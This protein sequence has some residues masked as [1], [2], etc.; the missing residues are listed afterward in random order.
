MA[1]KPLRRRQAGDFQDQLAAHGAGE[2]LEGLGDDGKGAGAADHAM[3]VKKVQ[4]GDAVIAAQAAALVQDRQAV[5]GHAGGNGAVAGRHH[6]AARVVGAVAGNIDDPARAGEGVGLDEGHGKIDGAADRGAARAGQR[7]YG[8][9]FGKGMGAVGAVDHPPIG[10]HHGEA[11][12]GP[13]EISHR[14]APQ[15]AALDGLNDARVAEGVDIALALQLGLG[16]IDAQRHI[17]RQ[18]QFQ[19]DGLGLGSLGLGSLGLGSLGLGS[20]GG[21]RVGGPNSGE[22]GTNGAPDRMHRAVLCQPR[23]G[24]AH[25][26]T[27]GALG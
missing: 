13:F 19:I 10:D 4:V 1:P 20:L 21:G 27:S 15:T 22:Q 23:F 2:I 3:A 12:A 8:Q 7:G 24:R 18:R 26:I 6:Q 17:D 25:I 5:D 16:G 14:D 9:C 11:V